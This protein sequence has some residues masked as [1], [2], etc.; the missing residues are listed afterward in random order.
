MTYNAMQN[1]IET[2]NNRVM[3]ISRAPFCRV[4]FYKA[5][6]LG[7]FLRMH[8]DNLPD[9]FYNRHDV[10]DTIFK[11]NDSN[12]YNK[13]IFQAVASGTIENYFHVIA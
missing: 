12:S 5:G 3:K 10:N 4:V 11:N 8:S 7:D 1:F 9:N 13:N 2:K 6:K